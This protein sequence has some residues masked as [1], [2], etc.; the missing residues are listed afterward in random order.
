MSKRI[1]VIDDDADNREIL[2]ELL[3]SQGYAVDTAESGPLGVDI[4]MRRRPHLVLLDL[5]LPKVDGFHTGELLARSAPSDWPPQIIYMSG[6]FQRLEH[7][8]R[9]ISRPG[10]ISYFVKPLDFDRLLAKIREVVG[11]G[12]IGAAASL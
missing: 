8:Q 5:L 2:T 9:V 1:L 3:T 10:T 12:R 11:P 4:F 7:V 6:I